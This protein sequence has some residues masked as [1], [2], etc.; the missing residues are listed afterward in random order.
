MPPDVPAWPRGIEDMPG[1]EGGIPGMSSTDI[2]S[3]PGPRSQAPGPVPQG[4]LTCPD[5]PHG[6]HSYSKRSRDVSG[7][8]VQGFRPLGV[9]L[10][11]EMGGAG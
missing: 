1:L 10:G 11:V 9:A 7:E 6:D 8:L 2:E 4:Y 3:R 5:A